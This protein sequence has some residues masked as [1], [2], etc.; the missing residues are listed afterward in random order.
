M[1]FKN[2]VVTKFL[3]CKTIR[4]VKAKLR[5]ED[6]LPEGEDIPRINIV[7]YAFNEAD[8]KHEWIVEFKKVRDVLVLGKD[9]ANLL[10][11]VSLYDDVEL[12]DA[13]TWLKKLNYPTLHDDFVELGTSSGMEP[14]ID[15]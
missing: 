4:Q 12:T 15:Q 2:G 5:S 9:K 1:S 13:N 8:L 7:K 3:H 6:K 14:W 11:E 10:E